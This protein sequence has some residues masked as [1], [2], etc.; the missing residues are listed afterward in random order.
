M[1][2]KSEITLEMVIIY[3][4]ALLFAVVVIVLVVRNNQSFRDL[5][6]MFSRIL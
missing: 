1:F 3:I 5:L 2:K 4:L 6:S